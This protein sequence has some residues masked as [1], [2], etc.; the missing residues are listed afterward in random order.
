MTAHLTVQWGGK[1]RALDTFG[2]S[3]F[4]CAMWYLKI[5]AFSVPDQ[6]PKI[7]EINI[8]IFCFLFNENRLSV[9]TKNSPGKERL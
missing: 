6:R 7:Y 2:V 4:L 5:D 9:L 8:F 1:G 3:N